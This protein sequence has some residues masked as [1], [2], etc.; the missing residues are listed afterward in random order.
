M[1]VVEGIELSFDGQAALRGLD[2]RVGDGQI[3][4]LLGP[5]GC[6][7]TSLLRI[8]AGLTVPDGGRVVL[9]GRD[10]AGVPTHQRGIGLMFQ[11]YALFPHRN[12]ADNV[13]F[14]LR[15]R[16]DGAPA[17]RHR[18]AEVL[19]LVGLAGF[20]DRAVGSL[21]G[22][23]KQRVALA[24]A[25][26]PSPALLM[27]DEP[28]GA[29][30]RTLRDRL[31]LELAELFAELSIGVVYVTHDQAEALALADQVVVMDAGRVVQQGTPEE[32]WS[33]PADP[34]VAR[35]LGL[36][37]VFGDVLIR[38]EAVRL[39]APG[40]PGALDGVVEAAAFRGDH[41][42]VWVVLDPGLRLEARSVGASRP[43]AGTPVGV[44]ID[45]SGVRSLGRP[46]ADEGQQARGHEEAAEPTEEPAPGVHAPHHLV[47]RP[48]GQGH[49]G[50]QV[51]RGVEPAVGDEPAQ[52]H[53]AQEHP[54]GHVGELGDRD[55]T[56]LPVA[57]P[58]VEHPP[59]VTQ[60]GEDAP[61]PDRA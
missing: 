47:D 13:A 16:G 17:R 31:V 11:D 59:S 8:V 45:P 60:P 30:D 10:L 2:L 52:D 44:V 22:G 38:P 61:D 5:S 28:L 12:V 46:S 35:F 23:E 43:A 33:S 21:S 18:V 55:P 24:R 50:H 48:P 51:E 19:A 56:G 58:P 6:G 53:R 54:Q 3:V 1:L 26:A 42:Q 32:V 57:E 40:E 37:N 7:K 25:L 9:D 4:A 14:G 29:L 39:V 27:L 36:S 20:G 34:F 15:M 41:T 49:Q